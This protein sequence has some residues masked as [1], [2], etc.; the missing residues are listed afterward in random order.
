MRVLALVSALL[1]FVG[2]CDTLSRKNAPR[3]LA[4][5]ATLELYAVSATG[6]AN[7]KTVTDPDTGAAVYLAT[8]AIITSTD[9]ATI[10]RSEDSPDLPSLTVHLTPTGATKLAA[11][12][13]SPNGMR[14]AFV[15]NGT[16]VSIPRVLS[17]MSS[18]FRVEGGAMAKNLDSLFDALTQA[19]Q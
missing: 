16:V 6:A 14:L 5:N 4:K 10:Q 2:G 9:V 18:G 7:T 15:L 13:A 12:T 8:P 1:L 11:A 17:P 3:P 19:P